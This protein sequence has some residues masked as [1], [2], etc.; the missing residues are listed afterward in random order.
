MNAIDT[1]PT[2]DPLSRDATHSTYTEG[3]DEV[4]DTL[5]PAGPRTVQERAVP[6]PAEGSTDPQTTAR[7][8][9]TTRASE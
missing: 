8:T 1:E 7:T 3:D 5:P 9:R 4:I 6:T 2:A